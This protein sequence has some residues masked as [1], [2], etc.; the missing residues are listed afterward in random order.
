MEIDGKLR[1]ARQPGTTGTPLIWQ[2]WEY[3]V[4]RRNGRLVVVDLDGNVLAAA[5]DYV[6]LGGGETTRQGAFTVCGAFEAYRSPATPP[7]TPGTPAPPTVS[8][9][10]AAADCTELDVPE[11]VGERNTSLALDEGWQDIVYNDD[12]YGNYVRVIVE[13]LDPACL[14]HPVIGPIIDHDMADIAEYPGCGYFAELLL[15][16]TIGYRGRP[17][18]DDAIDGYLKRWCDT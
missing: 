11:P 2:P 4:E 7:P 13:F 17:I 9:N 15:S 18:A 12:G 3:V 14:A 10:P 5:G 16:G 6:L 1:V 8:A